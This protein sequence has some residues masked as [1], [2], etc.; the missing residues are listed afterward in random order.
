MDVLIHSSGYG[1]KHWESC[2]SRT[3]RLSRCYTSRRVP[4]WVAISSSHEHEFV[5]QFCY[6]D[7]FRFISVFF[8]P[9]GQH[10]QNGLN[11][12]HKNETWLES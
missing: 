11:C 9:T 3:L 1:R 7:L 4:T 2:R 8:P 10:E 5:S 12:E 6:G